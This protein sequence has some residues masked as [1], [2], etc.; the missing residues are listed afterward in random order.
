MPASL[1]SRPRWRVHSRDGI[2]SAENIKGGRGSRKN[3]DILFYVNP[4]LRKEAGFFVYITCLNSTNIRPREVAR[5]EIHHPS[6]KRDPP[7]AAT[8]GGSRRETSRTVGRPLQCP[9]PKRAYPRLSLRSSR[10]KRSID[11]FVLRFTM[12]S[13][14]GTIDTSRRMKYIKEFTYYHK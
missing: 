2:C 14:I 1:P 10:S 11:C 9:L 7:P 12:P 13:D 8:D 4:V 6:T 3:Q 5:I